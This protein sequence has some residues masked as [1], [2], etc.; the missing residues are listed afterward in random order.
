MK[1]L[2]GSK[3]LRKGFCVFC[4]YNVVHTDT[5]MPSKERETQCLHCGY[6]ETYSVNKDEKDTGE[7]E[8]TQ[9]EI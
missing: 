5:I 2:R 1:R 6:Q 4:G 3:I 9:L 7:G 8:T